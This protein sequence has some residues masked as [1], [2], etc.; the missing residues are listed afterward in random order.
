MNPE[1]GL[2]FPREEYMRR[3][4]ATK[5]IAEDF[6]A[7][8]ENKEYATRWISKDSAQRQ[9]QEINLEL[10]FLRAALEPTLHISRKR[11]DRL[12]ATRY[13]RRLAI[14]FENVEDGKVKPRSEWV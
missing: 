4:E 9:I 11:W 1:E 7:G 3:L 13:D 10:D 14:K 6:L 5:A 8:L 2:T 12:V